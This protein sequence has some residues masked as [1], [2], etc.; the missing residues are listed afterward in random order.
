MLAHLVQVII[1]RKWWYL[2]FVL[3]A[4]GE[5]MGWAA[6]L[7]A[8]SCPYNN[9]AFML[10]IAILIIGKLNTASGLLSNST[11]I[12]LAPCFF[13]AALYYLQSE[14]IRKYGRKFSLLSPKLYLWIFIG[15][16]L[17]SIAVQGAGG[18]IAA[19]ASTSDGQSP[20]TGTHIMIAGIAIQLVSM[21]LFS[22]LLFW[23]AWSTRGFWLSGPNQLRD[24]HKIKMVMAATLFSDACIL[25]RNFYRAVEL[26]QGWSG[27]L[28]S[29]EA[30]FCVLDAGLMVLAVGIFVIIHPAFFLRPEITPLT[31]DS[32]QIMSDGDEELKG[33]KP[34]GSNIRY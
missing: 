13:S 25:A 34:E 20:D 10:Q 33:M 21:S 27:Y 3:G 14:L 8:H 24:A 15:F 9:Q 4:M 32:S 23:T 16:D 6:R 19:G 30:Y 18:G 22:L 28:I 7:Y 11:N 29:H 2:A 17:V 1:S 26:G 31:A 5:L 12:A